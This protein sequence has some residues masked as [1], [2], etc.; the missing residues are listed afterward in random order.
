MSGSRS[1]PLNR[2]HMA[3][4][5][6]KRLLVAAIGRQRY[7]DHVGF[8]NDVYHG[9]FRPFRGP[10][11]HL[12][13]QH[14]I[15][16]SGVVFDVGAHTGRFVRMAAKG[17]GPQGAVYAFEPVSRTYRILQKTVS[18]RRL[19]RVHL[20]NGA[21]SDRAGTAQITIP[22]KDGWKPQSPTAHLGAAVDAQGVSES[23][24]LE[25][26]DDFCSREGVSQVD[27]LKC[28]TEG[29]ESYVFQGGLEMLSASRP[30]IYVEI[31]EAW[32]ERQNLSVNVSFDLLRE[33]GYRSFLPTNEGGLRE[34]RG[35]EGAADY[36]F[37]HPSRLAGSLSALI[38]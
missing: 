14:F 12:I 26:L 32:L 22:L 8:W 10:G 17:V 3:D 29:H 15:P 7:V 9:A 18:L 2:P 11:A 19:D 21:L 5:A 36:F 23:V 34:T 20:V 38:S 37:I 35:Y 30:S 1:V 13:A 16:K 28:D 31:D 25:R 4:N 27:F 6:A 24:P 33:V